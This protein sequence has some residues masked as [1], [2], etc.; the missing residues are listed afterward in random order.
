M[1][2]AV[3]TPNTG[4]VAPAVLIE[5]CRAFEVPPPGAG[6]CTVKAIVPTLAMAEAGTCAV[7]W[8]PL[9]NCVARAVEPSANT[10]AEVNPEPFTVR[11]EDAP[12]ALVNAGAKLP[13]TGAGWTTISVTLAVAVV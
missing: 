1:T 10:D 4:G 13:R 6:F 7:N 8:V 3:E 9:A 11:V 2:V 5:N 12:P